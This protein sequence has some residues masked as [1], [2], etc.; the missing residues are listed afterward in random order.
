MILETLA[1]T[2]TEAPAQ[3][4]VETEPRPTLPL[5][6]DEVAVTALLRA[7]DGG[8][9]RADLKAFV[10]LLQ[11][12]GVER[13]EHRGAFGWFNAQAAVLAE[14]CST[15]PH[16]I[17]DRMRKFKRMGYIF[18]HHEGGQFRTWIRHNNQTPPPADEACQ[19]PEKPRPL[20]AALDSGNNASVH[21]PTP[22]DAPALQSGPG[23]KLQVAHG[24]QP[25]S[26]DGQ[27]PQPES[28]PDGRGTIVHGS[29]P[30]SGPPPF[31]AEGERSFSAHQT[32]AH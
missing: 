25:Q 5:E 21:F 14:D 29:Q 12:D 1:T 26:G 8:L 18:F 20:F 11:I 19:A 30:L 28:V 32:G 13:A 31:T 27:K 10:R 3:L 15:V 23:R 16:R 7:I 6:L 24:Q 17:R 4:P 2:Q 9:T 22:G